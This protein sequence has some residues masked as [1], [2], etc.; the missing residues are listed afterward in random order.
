M[1][2]RQVIAVIQWYFVIRLSSV[3]DAEFQKLFAEPVFQRRRT[4]LQHRIDL[5]AAVISKGRVTVAG[6]ADLCQN[7]KAFINTPPSILIQ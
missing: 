5:G 4:C 3:S 7:I 6:R 2:K 1:Y